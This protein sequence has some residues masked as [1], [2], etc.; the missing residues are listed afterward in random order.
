[1]CSS[2]FS[3]D[4]STGNAGFGAGPYRISVD[5]DDPGSV[6]VTD[7][8]DGNAQVLYFRTQF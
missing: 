3:N 7:A 1:M 5:P 4:Y 6:W 2:P 8:T